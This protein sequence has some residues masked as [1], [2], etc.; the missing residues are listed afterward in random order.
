MERRI[1]LARVPERIGP[2]ALDVRLRGDEV[3]TSFVARDDTGTR[4]AVRVL[5]HGN[6]PGFRRRFRREAERLSRVRSFCTAAVVHF[7]IDDEAAYLVTEYVDAPDLATTV[8]ADG[9]FSGDRLHRLA[10]G[11][12]LAL[13]AIHEADVV[14][15]DVQPAAIRWTAAGPVLTGFGVPTLLAL[16]GDAPAPPLAFAA[17]ERMRGGPPDPRSDMFSWA[18]TIRYAAAPGQV[19]EPLRG[20]LTR[21]MDAKPAARPTARQVYQALIE[22]GGAITA[23]GAPA[24]PPFPRRPRPPRRPRTA[25]E[26]ERSRRRSR[27]AAIAAAIVLVLAAAGTAAA[28]LTYGPAPQPPSPVQAP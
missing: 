16:A 6:T 18:A 12:A 28:Y 15:G 24:A 9:G 10:V 21:A 19:P 20:L 3:G 25:A 1:D 8:T 2:Y 22:A 13:E 4:V 27:L 5:R 11:T 23:P 7:A 14:H 17:P 26:L